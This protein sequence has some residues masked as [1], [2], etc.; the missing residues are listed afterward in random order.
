GGSWSHDDVIVFGDLRRGMMRV[1]A[2]GGVPA[3]VTVIDRGEGVQTF[4]VFLPDA[5][6]FLYGKSGQSDDADGIYIGAIDKEPSHQDPKRWL[7]VPYAP[8][9]VQLG[10]GRTK[11]LYLRSGTLMV[12]DFDTAKLQL[13]GEPAAVAE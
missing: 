5:R 3:R 4:P 1:P 9:I 8:Q 2:A 7:A 13:A 11:I 6:R 10:D 12:Q